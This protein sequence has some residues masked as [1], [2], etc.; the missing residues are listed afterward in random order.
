MN[1]KAEILGRNGW[2]TIA[3]FPEVTGISDVA[4]VS[5]LKTDKSFILGGH[6]GDNAVQ[7]IHVFGRNDSTFEFTWI[8]RLSRVRS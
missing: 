3:D 5:D 2:T 8:G 6:N 7:D 4:V 1:N